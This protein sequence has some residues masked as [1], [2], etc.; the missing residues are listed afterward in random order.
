M[1]NCEQKYTVTS[2]KLITAGYGAYGYG[3]IFCICQSGR[4]EYN[5]LL[6]DWG[7]GCEG[8]W[9]KKLSVRR[10]TRS[11]M[12]WMCRELCRWEVGGASGMVT[13]DWETWLTLRLPD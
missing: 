2:G 6:L 9:A 4:L 7:L 3:Y 11:G 10:W 8:Q 5:S 12:G 1:R 13:E